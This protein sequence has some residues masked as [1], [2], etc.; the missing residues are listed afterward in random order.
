MEPSPFKE[1]AKE[2]FAAAL[3]AAD[4]YEA[5]ARHGDGIRSAFREGRYRRLF[6]VSFGKAACPMARALEDRLGEEIT[7][8]VIL[9]KYGHCT[10]FHRHERMRVFEAGHPVPDE[11]GVR[12]TGEIIS[13]LKDSDERDMVV[14]ALSGGGSSLCVAPYD[15]IT[16]QDKQAV[17]ELLLRSGAD[18]HEINTVRKH[19][20][21]VKGGRLAEIAAPSLCRALILSDVAGDRPDVIA[22]G[23]TAPDPTTYRDALAVLDTYLLLEQTPMTVLEVVYRGVSGL[24]AETPKPGSAVFEKVENIIVGNNR[25]ALDAAL[26]KA[27]SMGLRAEIA[28]SALT[29]EAAE[30]GRRLARR[31]REIRN[32][33]ASFLPCCLLSGGETTVTLR[34]SGKGGRNMELALAFALE[35]EGAAGITL[36]SA[37]TDGTDGPTEAAGAL[38]DGETA[39]RARTQ[40]LSPEAFLEN[41]DSYRFFRETGGLFITGPTGTNVMDMQITI[42]E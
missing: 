42:V 11:N 8:G 2:I 20:S 39:A 22:S 31:A 18:I 9:T 13:L 27:E 3:K 25:T 23:P 15:G 17:T 5:V 33:R 28:P 38:A 29:G 36:L 41:N 1:M 24:W 34:G 6:V 7:A 30:A 37:G 21:R 19:L 4:P 14:F 40:G 35:A 10:P 26:L 16:L 12:G 32:S